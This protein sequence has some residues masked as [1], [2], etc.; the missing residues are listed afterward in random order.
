MLPMTRKGAHD[1]HVILSL[2]RSEHE[3]LTTSNKMNKI[4]QKWSKT[5]FIDTQT[6]GATTM[7]TLANIM[8][9]HSS[10]SFHVTSKENLGEKIRMKNNAHFTLEC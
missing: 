10:Q 6:E 8:A 7:N 5:N 9:K 1:W 2:E 3:F 4:Q